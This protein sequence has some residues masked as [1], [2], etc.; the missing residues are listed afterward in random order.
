MTGFC[1]CLGID[2][3]NQEEALEKGYL[4]SKPLKHAYSVDLG[5]KEQLLCLVHLKANQVM[6]VGAIWEF[7]GRSPV[8]SQDCL[9]H[10][11]YI[12]P[13]PT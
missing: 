12:N 1:P 3:G 13:S 10:P 5:L 11:L 8:I 6:R 4:C 9:Q 2:K 7:G